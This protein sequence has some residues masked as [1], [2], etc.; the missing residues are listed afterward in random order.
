[1]L[2]PALLHGRQQCVETVVT[3]LLYVLIVELRFL[4][5]GHISKYF[6]HNSA[7]WKLRESINLLPFRA[8]IH[9]GQSG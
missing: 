9:S 1:M 6:H 5:W 7:D 2:L 4:D 3:D 8:K